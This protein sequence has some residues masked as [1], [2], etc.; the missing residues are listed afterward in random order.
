MTEDKK[1]KMTT[2]VISLL[3]ILLSSG[4][5]ANWLLPTV[6][7]TLYASP[8]FEIAVNPELS[9]VEIRN[10]GHAAA[11]NTKIVIRIPGDATKAIVPFSSENATFTS[12]YFAST[13]TSLIIFYLR[14]MAEKASVS[15]TFPSSS[16]QTIEIWVQSDERGAYLIAKRS[17]QPFDFLSAVGQYFTSVQG[18]QSLLTFVVLV[19]ISERFLKIDYRQLFRLR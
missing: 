9:A 15:A 19:L 5:I 17:N 3:T 2:I 12:A 1:T 18:V 7:S 10:T 14:R 13:D 8:N 6:W 11:K 4:L 16:G